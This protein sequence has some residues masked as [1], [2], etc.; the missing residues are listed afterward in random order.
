MRRF[1]VQSCALLGSPGV[2]AVKAIG[3]ACARIWLLMRSACL[4][5]GNAAEGLLGEW[6]AGLR[7]GG[8]IVACR[9]QSVRHLRVETL[10]PSMGHAAL[11]E[12]GRHERDESQT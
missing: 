4:E 9:P 1:H 2:K 5:S 11:Q 7:E 8:G 10:L 3:A 6:S 12:D